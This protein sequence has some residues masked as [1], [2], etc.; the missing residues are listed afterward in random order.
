MIQF[1]TKLNRYIA[2]R[3][4]RTKSIIFLIVVTSIIVHLMSPNTTID[5]F[6]IS[7][8]SLFSGLLALTG[9][10]FAA[11]TFI[12][13]KLYETVYSSPI[14]W[15]KIN[16][17]AK[18]GAY[19]KELL[20]PLRALDKS[21]SITTTMSILSLFSLTFISLIEPPKIISQKTI[22]EII[23]IGFL[24]ISISSKKEII[25]RVIFPV[26]Y[27]VFSDIVCSLI[28]F[29]F[30][31]LAYNLRSINRNIKSIFDTWQKIANDNPTNRST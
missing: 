28:L 14:Y 18:E 15:E 31:Q 1:L 29:T 25:F 19:R 11:R 2:I 7:Y 20:A 21:L 27:K 6:K 22:I 8:N 23:K 30:V 4:R 16:K 3:L 10:V 5:K 9:F 26:L 17:L 12:I 13:F 24:N